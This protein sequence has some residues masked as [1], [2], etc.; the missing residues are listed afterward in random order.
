MFATCSDDSTVAIWDTRN[1]KSKIRSL[2]GHLNWVKNIEYSTK[3]GLLVTSGFDGSVFTW[4]M[5]SYT[6]QGFVYQ[7]VFHTPGL[8][9]CRISPDANQ[10]IICTTG[11]YLII[12]HNLELATLAKDLNGFKVTFSTIPFSINS[13]LINV[14][15]LLQPNVYRLMQLGRQFIPTAAEFDHVFSKNM[16]K[17]RVELVSDFPNDAEVISSLQIHPQGWCALSRNI[18]YDESTEFTCLHDIQH[19]D[20]DDDEEKEG[21]NAESE[22]QHR[23][24]NEDRVGTQSTMVELNTSTSRTSND[25][26]SESPSSNVTNESQ[27]LPAAVSTHPDIWA[28]EVTVRDR[29][30]GIRR[31]STGTFGNTHVYGISS[32]VLSSN[33]ALPVRLSAQLGANASYRYMYVPK[34]SIPQNVRRMLYSI[35]QPNKGKGLIKEEC[36]SS[37]GRLIC[38]PYDKGFRLLAFS[39][40]CLELP[41]ALTF[42]ME[43][44][45]LY[46]LKY[47]KCHSEIVVST[48]F[49]PIQPLLASGCLQGR[50]VWH[51]PRF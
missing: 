38:S 5:N 2:Q 6:E 39:Q 13:A 8:M 4:D 22:P 7:K 45:K 35:E 20:Y 28:A 51:Q 41:K 48:R 30:H 23:K 46:E 3:E 15:L 16:R 34:K 50:V 47:F 27:N 17:N 33:S 24:T 19:R 25:D 40:D 43:S 12:I 11:G 32:G 10:L 36:F 26:S 21:T 44:K 18:S 37:D 42:Q 1:L 31:N 9:R 49:S 29:M 14:F